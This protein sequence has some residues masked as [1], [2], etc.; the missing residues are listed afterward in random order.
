MMSLR[1]IVN[2]WLYIN[3]IWYGCIKKDA[4]LES[5]EGLDEE[6]FENMRLT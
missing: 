6:D 1:L 3:F 5:L 2:M 4:Q